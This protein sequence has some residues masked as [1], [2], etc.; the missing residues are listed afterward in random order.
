MSDTL[1][2]LANFLFEKYF[3][4]H[5]AILLRIIETHGPL[6]QKTLERFGSGRIPSSKLPTCIANLL[7][8]NI[9]QVRRDK[10][11]IYSINF[12]GVKF[13]SRIPFFWRIGSSFYGAKAENLILIALLSGMVKCSELLRIAL[14]RSPKDDL[15]KEAEELVDTLDLL[16]NSGALIASTK[17]SLL[18]PPE[19]CVQYQRFALSKNE[20]LENLRKF[21][22]VGAEFKNFQRF[23]PISVDWDLI[24]SPNTDHFEALWRD[25]LIVRLATVQI[26]ETA[27]EIMSK[28]LR[29]SVASKEHGVITSPL[30]ETVSHQQII[31][32]FDSP[33]NYLES[34]LTLLKEDQMSLLEEKAGIAGGLYLCP[35]KKL[36]RHML[37]RQTENIIQVLYD[38]AGL[39]IFRILLLEGFLT[40]ESLERRLLIPQQEFRKT[41]PQMIASCFVESKEFS[42]AKEFSADT[43]VCLYTVNLTKVAR[44]ITEFAQHCV[45]C[46]SSRCDAELQSKRR[47]VDKRYRTERLIAEHKAKITLLEEGEGVDALEDQS[48]GSEENPEDSLK[49]HKESV[50]ALQNSLTPAEVNQ[51]S[52]LANRLSKLSCARWEAETAWFISD[53][54]LRL[55]SN[56]K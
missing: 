25:Y 3:D 49:S 15:S 36:V 6:N 43:S 41:L 29:I 19:E 13:L 26:D 37:V 20:L 10:M 22:K 23:L 4:A 53:L 2:Y 9:L 51:L 35:Y 46:L 48:E 34:Y 17:S 11:P 47:L 52:T 38:N 39:R 16:V 8:C 32:A 56:V 40:W 7:R 33:P 1:V 54:Y 27:G 45:L 28:F 42:K 24:L 31:Q 21:I 50:Q 12:D 14:I 18:Q 30:S 5:C 55:Y 44:V